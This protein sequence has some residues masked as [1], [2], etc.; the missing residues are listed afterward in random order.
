MPPIRFGIIG[1]GRIA[2]KFAQ[3]IRDCDIG[4]VVTAASSHNAE[5]AREF[6]GTYG[7]ASHYASYDEMLADSG[8]FDAVY[9]ANTNEKHYACCLAGIEAGKH[10]LCEKPLVLTAG[11]ARDLKQKATNRGV[12]LMEAI[13]SRFLPAHQKAVQWALDGKIG[14]LRG[15]SATFCIQR[16]LEKSSRIFSPA[17]GGGSLYDIGIYCLQLIQLVTKGR[18]LQD[19]RALNIPS[20]FGAEIS[21]YVHLLYDDGFVADFKCSFGCRAPNEAHITGTGGYITIAPFFNHAQC[22]R[23][24]TAPAGSGVYSPAPDEVFLQQ[25]AS[26]FEFEIMHMVECI[27]KGLPESPICPLDDSIELAMLMERILNK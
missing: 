7:V 26:G 15:V 13:W 11:Q 22:V 10:I 14:K 3:T 6:A 4:A 24:F 16:E 23:L 1:L 18:T 5:R 19:V 21:N 8:R 25:A 12:F 2:E 20:G 27:Q 17:L 9:I